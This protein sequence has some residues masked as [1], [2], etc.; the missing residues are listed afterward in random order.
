MLDGA[1]SA[2]EEKEEDA[3]LWVADDPGAAGGE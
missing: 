3:F 1:R 2:E